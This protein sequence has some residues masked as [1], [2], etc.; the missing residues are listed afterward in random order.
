MLQHALLA[1]GCELSREELDQRISRDAF[2]GNT[3]A[4]VYNDADVVVPFVFP[5]DTADVQCASAPSAPRTGAEL[6]RQYTII[7]YYFTQIYEQW[8]RSGRNDPRNFGNFCNLSSA[9][10]S[11]VLGRKCFVLLVVLRCKYPNEFVDLLN[12]TLRTI[13]VNAMADSGETTTPN[14]SPVASRR[15]KKRSVIEAIGDTLSEMQT[16]IKMKFERSTEVKKQ[17]NRSELLKQMGMLISMR[18][19]VRNND[20]AMFEFIKEQM[21]KVQKEIRV[22]S[23]LPSTAAD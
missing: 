10:T 2:R 5:I 16:A 3:V 17:K 14:E 22:A 9:S 12:I 23:K 8:S 21:E 4:P 19:D 11:N 1:S 7:R 6:K 15:F 18:K 20:T 13:P